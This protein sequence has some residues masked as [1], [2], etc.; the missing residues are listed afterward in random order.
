DARPQVA[1]SKK[2]SCNA[3]PDHTLGSNSTELAKATSPFMSAML[4]HKFNE[5]PVRPTIRLRQAAFGRSAAETSISTRSCALAKM[6]SPLTARSTERSG[7]IG[8]RNAG[9][10]GYKPPERTGGRNAHLS[11]CVFGRPRKPIFPSV[12][13]AAVRRDGVAERA[14]RQ[15]A[16]TR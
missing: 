3:R 2:S 11:N 15:S 5:L 9:G 10:H 16:P 12:L 6:V 4:H 8:K 14:D 7:S 13:R 1:N